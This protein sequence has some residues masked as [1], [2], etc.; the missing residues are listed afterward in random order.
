MPPAKMMTPSSSPP[1]PSH[2]SAPPRDGF[3]GVHIGAGQARIAY[4]GLSVVHIVR[5]ILGL[6]FLMNLFTELSMYVDRQTLN[7][8][9]PLNSTL[10]RERRHI[11]R[12]VPRHV[13]GQSRCYSTEA[14]HS[15]PPP[16]PQ[17][18]LR[19]PE[20]PMLV[21][22]LTWYEEKQQQN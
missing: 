5:L 20:R 18:S 6:R 17:W 19:T 10:K 11:C 9:I 4:A 14:R 22:G 7:V 12:Y 16:R 21:T 2:E 3:V 1:P 13:R 15:R 8:F